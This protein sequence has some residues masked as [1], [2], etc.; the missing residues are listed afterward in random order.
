[1]IIQEINEPW[2]ENYEK[3]LK[4]EKERTK[5]GVGFESDKMLTPM[6]ISVE[7]PNKTFWVVDCEPEDI[8]RWSKD[9]QLCMKTK[10]I[11]VMTRDEWMKA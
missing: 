9:Y 1:M 8:I 4:I 5:K 3:I 7:T 11:P 2:E 6:F 10:I